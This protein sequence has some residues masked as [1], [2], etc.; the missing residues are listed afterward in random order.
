MLTEIVLKNL[1]KSGMILVQLGNVDGDLNLLTL[2]ERL[3][4]TY[5]HP[6]GTDI[7]SRNLDRAHL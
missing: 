3:G 7:D 4:T 2:G 5:S 1:E 6:T